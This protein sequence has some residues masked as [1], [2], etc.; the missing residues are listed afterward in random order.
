VDFVALSLFHAAAALVL[1]ALVF[2]TSRSAAFS[3]GRWLLIHLDV[4]LPRLAYASDRHVARMLG[5]LLALASRK[6]PRA[7]GRWRSSA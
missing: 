6:R 5:P 1:G 4:A 3:H 2:A 7:G